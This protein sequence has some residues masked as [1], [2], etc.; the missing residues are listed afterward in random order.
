MTDK[1]EADGRW[2]DWTRRSERWLRL[3]EGRLLPTSPRLLPVTISALDADALEGERLAASLPRHD[4]RRVAALCV[5][6]RL[7]AIGTELCARLVPVQSAGSASG[8][9]V[10]VWTVFV[11]G[12]FIGAAIVEFLI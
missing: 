3:Y 9:A 2:R 11:A 8:L 12:L 7:D 6:R 5:V 10:R 1:H 4:Y